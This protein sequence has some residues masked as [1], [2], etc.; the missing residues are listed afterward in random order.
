MVGRL[1]M[2]PWFLE[3]G[4]K[5]KLPPP[6]L[7][8]AD[9]LGTHCPP[10]RVRIPLLI[11]NCLFERSFVGALAS[12]PGARWPKKGQHQRLVP[13]TVNGTRE[14]LRISIVPVG[15]LRTGAKFGDPPQR[16]RGN[17]SCVVALKLGMVNIS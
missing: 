11:P 1:Q 9:M 8:A 14:A 5:Q 7:S 16:G 17:W 10:A 12:A 3:G 2:R 4:R 15:G 6:R 13:R